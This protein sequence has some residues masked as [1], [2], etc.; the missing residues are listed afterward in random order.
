MAYIVMA[1]VVM[2]YRNHRCLY[3]CLYT[4]YTTPQESHPCTHLQGIRL[5]SYGLYNYGL[6][7]YG[8]YRYGH[9]P[10]KVTAPLTAP[11]SQSCRCARARP[12][13][14]HARN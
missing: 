14:H 12:S 2:G 13:E 5:Y 7:S 3:K 9:A 10:T 1:Y 11:R 6:D 8:L 4:R